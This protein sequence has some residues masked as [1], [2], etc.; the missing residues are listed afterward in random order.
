MRLNM[1]NG[2]QDMKNTRLNKRSFLFISFVF[3]ILLEMQYEER[4]GEGGNDMEF[5]TPLY[6]TQTMT[7]GNRN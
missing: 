7:Q 6:R 4:T 3:K 1:C 5:E 2:D